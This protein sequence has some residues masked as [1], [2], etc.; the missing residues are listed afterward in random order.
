MAY[1]S[2]PYNGFD[3][4]FQNVRGHTQLHLRYPGNLSVVRHVI[5]TEQ[6]RSKETVRVRVYVCMEVEVGY[7]D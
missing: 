3:S 6:E 4:L 7:L 5:L 1:R 2:S